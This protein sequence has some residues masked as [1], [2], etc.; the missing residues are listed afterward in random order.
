MHIMPTLTVSDIRK[1]FAKLYLEQKFT[2]NKNK[3]GSKTVEIINAAFIADEEAIFGEVNHD[4]VE[5]E[6]QWYRS[7]SLSISDIPGGAPK[8]WEM[9]A[10]KDGKI[11]S[12]YGWCIFSE[13]N[14][15]QYEACLKQLQEDEFSRRA[16]MI[17]TRPSI[18][19]EYN[20][21]GMSDFICTEA[22]QYFIRNGELIACVK[23]RS[24]DGWAGFRNDLAWQKEV[25]E[26][27]FT[28]LKRTYPALKLGPIVWG[29]GSIHIYERQFYLIEHFIKTGEF[30]I[31][32]EDYMKLYQ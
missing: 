23:M 26:Q 25:Q 20:K 12:N 31:S 15:S 13:E 7:K 19:V 2:E 6:S 24:N 27:L 22:V 9:V 17:Y 3:T 1:L 28:D 16:E 4:Y 11:N 5:R 30:H 10:S 18:Q 21:N 8:I 32:K 14:Y 29:A